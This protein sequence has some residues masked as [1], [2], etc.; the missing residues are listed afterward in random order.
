[1]NVNPKPKPKRF[2]K[3]D[4]IKSNPIKCVTSTS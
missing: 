2:E 4:F 1:M 3:L